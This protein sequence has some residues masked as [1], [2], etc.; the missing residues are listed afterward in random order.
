MWDGGVEGS[1]QLCLMSPSM[2]GRFNRGPGIACSSVL[3]RPVLAGCLLS[4]LVVAA[5][6]GHHSVTPPLD[7]DHFW[8]NTLRHWLL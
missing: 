5:L 8:E 1:G 2:T 3:R 7:P 6:P 4:P